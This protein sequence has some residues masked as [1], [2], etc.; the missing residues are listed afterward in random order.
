MEVRRQ[1]REG[2]GA[3]RQPCGA[4]ERGSGGRRGPGGPDGQR[5]R[6]GEEKGGR[7]Q[8]A[9]GCG[10]IRS[11]RAQRRGG[12]EQELAHGGVAREI[13]GD[14]AAVDLEARAVVAGVTLEKAEQGSRPDRL[15]SEAMPARELGGKPGVLTRQQLQ[16]VVPLG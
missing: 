7:Q 5:G 13:G 9:Q 2:G 12:L 14:V 4:F 16:T 3:P 11:G 1:A 10:R 8:Q 6:R 15:S